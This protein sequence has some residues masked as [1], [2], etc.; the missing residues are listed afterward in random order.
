MNDAK[1][2]IITGI[3]TIFHIYEDLG[4]SDISNQIIE[5][6]RNHLFL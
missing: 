1:T 4:K 3:W 2:H 5:V 6:V